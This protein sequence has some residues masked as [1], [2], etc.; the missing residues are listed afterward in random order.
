M[1]KYNTNKEELKLSLKILF[2]KHKDI[3][4]VALA[5]IA[6]NCNIVTFDEVKQWTYKYVQEEFIK[7]ESPIPIGDPEEFPIIIALRKGLEENNY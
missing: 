2:D 5:K 6:I 1:K 3:W 4:F 7:D